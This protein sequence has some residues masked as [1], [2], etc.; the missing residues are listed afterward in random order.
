MTLR[1]NVVKEGRVT[2]M[3]HACAATRGRPVSGMPN[4]LGRRPYALVATTQTTVN[5][6]V[7]ARWGQVT[8]QTRVHE[9]M[10]NPLVSESTLRAMPIISAPGLVEGKLLETTKI[11][12]PLDGSRLW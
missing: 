10:M 2:V 5:A 8:M 3:D 4:P 7:R 9:L 1:Q 6:F 11:W 12:V